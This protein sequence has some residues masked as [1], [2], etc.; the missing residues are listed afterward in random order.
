MGNI[1]SSVNDER[2]L[3]VR[4]KVLAFEEKMPPRPEM[5]NYCNNLHN[6]LCRAK[7]QSYGYR[8]NQ[9]SILP[10]SRGS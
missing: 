7:M 2:T 1:L 9:Q 4:D 5:E 3:S 6:F 8:E 10:S